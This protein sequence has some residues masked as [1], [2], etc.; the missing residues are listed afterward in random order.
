M[1]GKALKT[2]PVYESTPSW[3][4][5]TPVKGMDLELF[6]DFLQILRSFTCAF[7]PLIWGNVD[8]ERDFY[9]LTEKKRAFI[10][11]GMVK[12]HQFRAPQGFVPRDIAFAGSA[13]AALAAISIILR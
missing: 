7:N 3:V 4:C 1:A 11:W 2:E 12:G 10:L 5:I 8:L 9:S 13:A 6:Q